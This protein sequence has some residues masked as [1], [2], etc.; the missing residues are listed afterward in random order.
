MFIRLLYFIFSGVDVRTAREE[1]MFETCSARRMSE[2]LLLPTLQIAP[3][4]V[5]VLQSAERRRICIPSSEIE[6]RKVHP[7]DQAC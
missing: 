2:I 1:E 3:T 6:E 7:K 4:Q 5:R